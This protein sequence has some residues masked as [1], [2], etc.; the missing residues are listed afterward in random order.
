MV[1]SGKPATASAAPGVIDTLSAGFGQINRV[2]WILIF[3][4][5][6]DVLLWQ[7]PRITAGPVIHDLTRRLSDLY[8]SV[9]ASGIDPTTL[10]QTRQ[11]L[12]DFDRSANSF[13]L[14][15]LL[16]T[17]LASLPSILPTPLVGAPEI[18]LTTSNALFGALIGLELLGTLV[19]CLYLGILAQQVRD[20]QASW[21]RLGGRVW[22]Y[23]FS[24]IG[25]FLLA[26]GLTLLISVPLGIA[27]GAVSLIVP[28]AGTFL[29]LLVLAGAQIF[30]VLFLIYLFFLIDAIVISEVGPIR[31]AISSARVVA[32]N[33]WSALG[34][35]LIVSIISLGMQVIWSAVAKNPVGTG[36]AIIGN[37][38]IASGL[39]AASMLF[40]RNRVKGLPAA[41]GVI[42]RMTQA[43]DA[44]RE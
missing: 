15:S 22:R 33:F 11:A 9:S 23:W 40:Y 6:M 4:I 38:Y 10:D 18:T 8:D 1:P 39:T 42:G 14:L 5:L 36:F 34:F 35:I 16:V 21:L 24:I 13:N 43:R 20:G 27:I 3:P 19:G 2:L 41:R 17:N 25:F 7:G 44:G 28:G 26:I 29:W 37:A 30:G 12:A 31:A 32:N